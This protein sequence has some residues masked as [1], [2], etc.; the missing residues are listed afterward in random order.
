[1]GVRSSFSREN[2]TVEN[3]RQFQYYRVTSNKCHLD[4]LVLC[5]LEI[6]WSLKET[7]FWLIRYFFL[8]MKYHGIH[9]A[10]PPTN[11]LVLPGVNMVLFLLDIRSL[12]WVCLHPWPVGKLCY[13]YSFNNL[14]W[15]PVIF[16][17]V[18][19][20]LDG[21]S[22]I[23]SLNFFFFYCY[24]SCCC[25]VTKSSQTLCNSMDCSTP[26]FLYVT[27]F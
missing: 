10:R 22:I 23:Y 12:G 19:L 15:Y 17:C 3:G 20:L 14:L 13:L 5:V 25:S 16:C 7:H 18:M 4:H 2:S 24:C 11:M 21:D 6:T 1:M 8:C 9:K 27:I 26:G